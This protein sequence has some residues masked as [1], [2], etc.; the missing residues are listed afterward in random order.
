M[1]LNE[2]NFR[3]CKAVRATAQTFAS[4][5]TPGAVSFSSAPINP[6][7]MWEGVTNPTRITINKPGY[8]RF[9][10]YV[11]WTAGTLGDRE[12]YVTKNGATI[13]LARQTHAVAALAQSITVEGEA[14]LISG[15]YLQL[16]VNQTSTGSLD[17]A[18]TVDNQSPSLT[19]TL[20]M[21]TYSPTGTY[22]AA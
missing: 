1:G 12:A 3:I 18:A 14:F 4:S 13:V 11:T 2:Q 20:L 19:V 22:E 7:S 8:Y 10:G 9:T 6:N 15:D 16:Y 21:P 17:L 5:G